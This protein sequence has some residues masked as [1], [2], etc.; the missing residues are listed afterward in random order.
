M[1]FNYRIP[2]EPQTKYLSL[3]LT[4][5]CNSNCIFCDR[6]NMRLPF[7][8][9]T[10]GEAKNIVE[11]VLMINSL[12]E[13][14]NL[15]VFGESTLNPDLCKM[16]Q[17]LAEK[18]IPSVLTTNAS[19]LDEALSKQLLSHGLKKCEFSI[20]AHNKELYEKI[21]VGLDWDTVLENT[22]TFNELAKAYNC[23]IVITA[24]MCEENIGYLTE[25]SEFWGAKDIR[26]TLRPELPE[27]PR[28][29]GERRVKSL[30]FLQSYSFNNNPA[31]AN[32]C[33]I[34]SNGDLVSCCYDLHHFN[35]FGNVFEEPLKDI[36]INDKMVAFRNRV[37]SRDPPEFCRLPPCPTYYHFWG[38][39]LV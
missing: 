13:Y 17:Y 18:G 22:L 32:T 24:V 33:V 29:L 20:D 12:L 4:N 5:R 36:W 27:Y 39:H 7:R 1:G 3:E 34:K 9:M 19:L 35:V 23:E 2:F 38:R 16:V 37:L 21:R 8:D 15:S 10:F 28:C 11:D 25:I 30:N 14:V 6:D 31:C 26:L